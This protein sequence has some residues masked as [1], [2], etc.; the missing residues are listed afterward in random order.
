MVTES[1]SLMSAD[2]AQWSLSVDGSSNSLSSSRATASTS[3]VVGRQIVSGLH[4]R[5]VFSVSL[6]S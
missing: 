2:S 1:R 5:S 4:R 3:H 6:P